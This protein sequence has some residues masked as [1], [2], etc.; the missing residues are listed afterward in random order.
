MLILTA[1]FLGAYVRHCVWVASEAYSS[2]SVVLAATQ[3]DGSRVIF[4]DFRESY[5]WLSHNTPEDARIMSWWDYGYQ[6][7]QMAN[8]TVFVDNN[9]W[10]NTHIATI[11]K[12]FALDEERSYELINFLGVDYVMVLFGGYSGYSGDDINKFIW[13]IR[14]AGSVDP[15]IKDT[16]FYSNGR[17]TVGADASPTLYNSLMFKLS[18]YDFGKLGCMPRLPQLPSPLLSPPLRHLRKAKQHHTFTP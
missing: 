10:N 3:P 18:Y 2:P 15:S 7:S 6:M 12:V 4:D 13:M 17:Y 9:T 1:V 8:R 11:G 16:D 14:I 5:R